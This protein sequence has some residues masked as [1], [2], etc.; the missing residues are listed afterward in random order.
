[1]T[2]WAGRVAL[3]TGAGSGIGRASAELFAGAGARVAVI[4]RDTGP[5]EETAELIRAAGGDAMF[6]A[7][8]VADEQSVK[9]M[10]DRTLAHY[11][12]LDIAHNNAGISPSTGT[13]TEC[14][15]QLWDQVLAVNLTG[16]YLC[17]KYQI[18]A[19]LRTGG[20]AIVLTGSASSLK[21]LPGIS[22]YVASKHGLTGLMKVA[23]LEYAAQNIRVNMICP[24]FTLSPLL[25]SNVES[26]Y[27]DLD[28]VLKGIPNR[29]M[30]MPK[31]Q[32]QAAFWLCSD[33]ASYVTGAVLSV[34]GGLVL[35]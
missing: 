25:A 19:M 28:E 15:R 12:R 13:V 6:I 4:D 5:G 8:D 1:M 2:D 17:M 29:R 24:G 16:P 35:A 14:S 31:D 23:A 7:G 10:V 9:D 3:I 30:S 11:G 33:E 26:G 27:L 21:G 20:G 22:A 18:D 34:D 32:A